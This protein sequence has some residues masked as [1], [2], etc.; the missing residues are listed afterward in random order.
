VSVEQSR[1][2][3]VVED[4]AEVRASARLL[5]ESTGYRVAEFANAEAFLRT[6]DG[7]DAACLVFDFHMGGMTGLEL[8]E[9]LRSAGVQTPAIIVTAS[10]ED[11]QARC[12]RAGTLALLRKPPSASDMLGWIAR[13]CGTH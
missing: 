5:L 8:L 3:C 9:N 2:V 4:D 1:L 12:A 10:A 11:L 7:R 6:T 13:A